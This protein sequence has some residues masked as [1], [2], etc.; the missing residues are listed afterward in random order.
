MPDLSALFRKLVLNHLLNA[1][2]RRAGAQDP[3]VQI[4][5]LSYIRLVD[6]SLE[7]YELSRACFTEYVNRESAS[8]LSPLLRAIGH[9]ENC[10]ATLVRTIGY[11]KAMANHPEMSE[12]IGALSIL[13]SGNAD[14]IRKVRNSIVHM[15]ERI[16]HGKVEPGDLSALW[17]DEEHMTLEGRSITYQE[18][19]EWLSELHALAGRLA[20]HGAQ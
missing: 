17:M 15:D 18:L 4:F 20:E 2:F 19:G 3:K 12:K 16:L 13:A 14:R 9:M 6:K 1:V 5:L 11:V 7:D 10:L 8:V